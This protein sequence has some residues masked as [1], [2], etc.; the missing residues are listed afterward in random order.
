MSKNTKKKIL[1][2]LNKINKVPTATLKDTIFNFT[3]AETNKNAE[4]FTKFFTKIKDFL[5]LK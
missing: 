5:D 2:K 3:R 4:N 1:L